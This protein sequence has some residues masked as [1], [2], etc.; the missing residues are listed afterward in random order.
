LGCILLLKF[1]LILHEVS[2]SIYRRKVELGV[3]KNKSENWC[4]KVEFWSQ[5]EH[6]GGMT[7]NLSKLPFPC[8]EVLATSLVSKLCAW[9]I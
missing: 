7:G 3:S 5:K 2:S 4:W 1:K 6:V 8:I 9:R